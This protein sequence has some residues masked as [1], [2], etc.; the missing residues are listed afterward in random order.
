LADGNTLNLKEG[1][2]SESW[3]RVLKLKE[4]GQWK[5]SS[6]VGGGC[7]G[8]G[9]IPYTHKSFLALESS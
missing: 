4:G 9:S 2:Y 5:T 7:N 3:K 1:L 6:K 8:E